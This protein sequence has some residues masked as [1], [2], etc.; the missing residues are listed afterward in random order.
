MHLLCQQSKDN[1]LYFFLYS[2]YC[3]LYAKHHKHDLSVSFTIPTDTNQFPLPLGLIARSMPKPER[4]VPFLLGVGAC[5]LLYKSYC[6]LRAKHKKYKLRFSRC[7]LKKFVFHARGKSSFFFF[8]LIAGS[9][10][11]KDRRERVSG[12]QLAIRTVPF[13]SLGFWDSQGN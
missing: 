9:V 7:F 3:T 8:L 12:I 2:L 6:K 13:L 5:A 4:Q 11:K 10:P 1:T